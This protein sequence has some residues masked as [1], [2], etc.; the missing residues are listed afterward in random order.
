MSYQ[1][2]LDFGEGPE[3]HKAYEDF[4]KVNDLGDTN[5]NWVLF[6]NCWAQILKMEAMFEKRGKTIQ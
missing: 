4:L 2:K 3:C 6:L 5:E 1:Y